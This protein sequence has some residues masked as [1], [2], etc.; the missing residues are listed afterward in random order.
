[1]FIPENAG[2][3]VLRVRK[4]EMPTEYREKV[5]RCFNHVFQTFSLNHDYRIDQRKISAKKFDID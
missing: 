1:M 3:R 5:I 2:D 4:T